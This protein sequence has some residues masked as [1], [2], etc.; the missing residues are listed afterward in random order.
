MDSVKKSHKT[1][2]NIF[3]LIGMPLSG[4]TSIGRLLAKYFNFDL[5]DLD[6]AII[7]EQQQSIPAIFKTQGEDT[8]RNIER[9]ELSKQ[10]K[11][12]NTIVSCGGGT[13]C[14]F[15]NLEMMKTAGTVIFL[16][17]PM[18][19]LQFRFA[20][21]LRNGRPLL[22]NFK[23][24]E[25]LYLKRRGFYNQA[26]LIFENKLTLTKDVEK[27]AKCIEPFIIN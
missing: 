27:L 18:P 5:V 24:L 21:L 23:T 22:K 26:D 13:P 17:T 19:I 14:F 9:K 6:E 12:A 2:K 20:Q 11:R 1:A 10:L 7:R 25:Q 16:D 3:F 15:D 8:F 4:K